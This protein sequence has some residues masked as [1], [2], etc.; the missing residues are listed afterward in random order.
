MFPYKFTRVVSSFY[1]VDLQK[2]SQEAC[3]Q[4]EGETGLHEP[5]D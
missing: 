5:G 3:F 2:V 4:I 1:P